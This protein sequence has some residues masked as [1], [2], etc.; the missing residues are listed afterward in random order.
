[1][2][3]LEDQFLL[4]KAGG[5]LHA[6]VFRNIVQVHNALV[7]E[8]DKIERGTA[9]LSLLLFPALLAGMAVVAAMLLARLLLRRP[10]LT[11]GVRVGLDRRGS[12]G[13]NG[14]RRGCFRVWGV[15]AWSV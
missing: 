10:V 3:D 1:L 8:F 4:A 15:R 9:G 12:I 14:R 5:V 7:F 11:F 13:G 6:H 2:Q